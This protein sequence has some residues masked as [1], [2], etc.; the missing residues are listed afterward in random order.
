MT[1]FYVAIGGAIGAVIRYLVV[2]G[3]SF[4]MGT[5]AVNVIGSFLMGLAFVWLMAKGMDRVMLLLMTGVLGGFTTFSAFSLDVLRLVEDGR[6][7]GAVLYVAGSVLLSL[8]A[9]FV[10]VSIA[11]A[12]VS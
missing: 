6:I 1:I 12:V 10:A 4:P 9:I 7:S 11:R 5:L 8:V 2:L 3:V